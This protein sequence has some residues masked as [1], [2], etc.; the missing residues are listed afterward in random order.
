MTTRTDAGQADGRPLAIPETGPRGRRAAPLG[1]RRRRLLIGAQL[2]LL[3]AGAVAVLVIFQPFADS[4]GGC[5]G[6]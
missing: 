1:R 3:L 5:G 6:G 2:L 4:V